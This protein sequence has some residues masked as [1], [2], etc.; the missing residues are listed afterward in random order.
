MTK[1][2]FNFK[3]LLTPAYL[4]ELFISVSL[5]LFQQFG[6]INPVIFN[7]SELLRN[8]GLFKFNLKYILNGAELMNFQYCKSPWSSI[9]LLRWNI[10]HFRLNIRENANFV[11]FHQEINVRSK[12]SE[13]PFYDDLVMTSKTLGLICKSVL[14]TLRILYKPRHYFFV[15]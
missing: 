3:P 9:C 12:L 6:G 11:C 2:S 1:R 13:Q 10:I 7:T 14:K 15:M 8:A 4:H 5:M